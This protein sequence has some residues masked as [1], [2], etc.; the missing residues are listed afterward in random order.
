MSEVHTILSQMVEKQ[1][2]LCDQF[3]TLQN[4]NTK[5]EDEIKILKQENYKLRI[6][7]YKA[8]KKNVL[9]LVIGRVDFDAN[10]KNAGRKIKMTPRKIPSPV[11]SSPVNHRHPR[12]SAFGVA[13]MN[14][15]GL[16]FM[17]LCTF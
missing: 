15:L 17:F 9:V 11:F 6:R 12:S 7:S 13:E 2:F 14:V 3:C 5:L 8:R 4:K 10:K 16:K 1:N